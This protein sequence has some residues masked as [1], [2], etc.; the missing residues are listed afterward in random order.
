MPINTNKSQT[1]NTKVRKQPFCISKHNSTLFAYKN[2]AYQVYKPKYKRLT[3]SIVHTII[4]DYEI[5]LSH[6]SKVLVARIDL[7]PNSYSVDNQTIKLFLQQ[8][9]ELLANKYLCKIIYH[10]AREQNT[11]DTEHY[12]LEIMLSAHKIKHSSKLLKLIKAKWAI[13]ANGTVSFVDNP[14]CIIFRGNKASL[15]EAVYRSSYLA[16]EHTKELNGK[17]KG[18]ISN[19]LPPAKSFGPTNDLMLVAPN[20]TF[21]KNKRKLLYRASQTT[22]LEPMTKTKK[23]SPYGWFNALSH[24]QQLKEC[25]ASRTTSLSHLTNPPPT[26]KRQSYRY[27]DVLINEA[28]DEVIITQVAPHEPK[29]DHSYFDH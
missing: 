15:K 24:A 13:H 22:E 12:H 25:I 17:A 19:K 7:H 20:I 5:M 27:K 2:H 9:S 16:K 8:I 28:S 3:K 1:L 21:E 6:Y 29:S 10:C 23:L 11:S 4:S 26:Q 18:F 14:F